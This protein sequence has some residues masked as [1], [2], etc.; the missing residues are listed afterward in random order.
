MSFLEKDLKYKILSRY[1]GFKKFRESQEEIIENVL[2]GKD[3]LALLPTG[4]GKSLC[5]QLPAIILEGTCLVIS[6][7]IAL[8]EDQVNQLQKKGIEA[9]YLNSSHSFRDIDRILDNV[10]YGSIKILYVSPERIKSN[11]FEERFKKM[12]ISFVAIDEAHCISEW[13]N[14]FRPD[15]RTISVL[16]KWK[17]NLSFIALTASA[18]NDVIIDIQNQLHFKNENIIQKSYLRENIKYKIIDSIDK[19][20][21]LLKIVKHECTIIY[22]KTRRETEYLSDLLNKNGFNTDFY[23]GG[24]NFEERINKQK[25]W[26]NNK[27]KIIVATNAFGMGID[28]SDVRAV[29]H[30]EIS[31]T[32]E[33]FYQESGRAGR[34]GKTSYSIILKSED[35]IDNLKRKWKINYPNLENIKKVFQSI[36][37]FHQIGIGYFSENNYELDLDLIAQKV[38]LSRTV[39]YSCIKYLI[40]ENFIKELNEYQYSKIQIIAPIQ[41]LNRFLKSYSKFENIIDIIIR[42]YSNIMFQLV[43]ISENIISKRL[44]LDRVKTIHLLA[45]LQEQ[46]IIVYE[47]KKSTN[48]IQFSVPRPDISRL[49]L[50]KK[51]VNLKKRGE[52]KN[53][54]VIDFINSRV[55]CRNIF[56]MNYFGEF[57]N[58][59]CNSCDNCQM[60]LNHKHNPDKIIENAIFILLNYEPKSPN[61]IYN[62]FKSLIEKNHFKSILKKMIK[63]EIVLINNQNL[64]YIK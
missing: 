7:L 47:K 27:L 25:K 22:A 59:K 37:N 4:G 41:N 14:D 1:W 55:K 56:M 23:H 48:M 19:K 8:M 32:I 34:D 16:K 11:L 2:Q 40:N 46:N 17:P 50:S 33:S 60:G 58:K 3:V 54:A 64:L 5:Y 42:S 62:Q 26:I 39:T 45:Q 18:T 51:Y 49:S 6:P 21:V 63:K 31:N 20:N 61:Y 57:S 53:Q 24:L 28:K 10:I 13:G 43:P 44:N 38:K 36:S 29:I 9:T 12:N 30:Y 35:D 52:E 15:Y